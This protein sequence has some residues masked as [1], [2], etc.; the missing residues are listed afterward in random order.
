[1]LLPPRPYPAGLP[2]LGPFVLARGGHPPSPSVFPRARS[3]R[4]SAQACAR[5]VCVLGAQGGD[6]CQEGSTQW[7][8]PPNRYLRV[9][10]F[11][12]R[13]AAASSPQSPAV[14]AAAGI[15]RLHLLL[16][17]SSA[18]TSFHNKVARAR[19]SAKPSTMVPPRASRSYKP[20]QGSTQWVAVTI[21]YQNIV[22]QYGQWPRRG[23]ISWCCTGSWLY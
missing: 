3:A 6:L 10:C 18:A 23:M 11:G 20:V 13:G 14:G 19:Q 21:W 12:R 22:C 2:A 16:E 15:P 17:P 9:L 7:S 1:M 8:S 5:S 4:N